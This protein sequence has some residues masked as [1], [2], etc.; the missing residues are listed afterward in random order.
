[1]QVELGRGFVKKEG[2]E[3]EQGR[4]RGSEGLGIGDLGIRKRR[5]FKYDWFSCHI[6]IPLSS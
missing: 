5:E 2:K 1:M 6:R 3:T 4:G